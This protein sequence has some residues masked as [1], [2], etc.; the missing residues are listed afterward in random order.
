M[1]TGK[2][3]TSAEGKYPLSS[4][5]TARGTYEYQVI[6]IKKPEEVFNNHDPK[7]ICSWYTQTTTFLQ[8]VYW[9]IFYGLL[10]FDISVQEHFAFGL[11]SWDEYA[12][13][14]SVLGND[15]DRSAYQW[16]L[17]FQTR[18]LDNDRYGHVNNAVYHG[19]F[20][21]VINIFLIRRCGLDI[22]MDR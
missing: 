18:W 6:Q 17:P 4:I 21:S 9:F 1:I 22:S 19:I 11:P 5:A 13:T 2:N 8:Y 20:D 15:R 14:S 16:F 10:S 3:V 7:P 12:T